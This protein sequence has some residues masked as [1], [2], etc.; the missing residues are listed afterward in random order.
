M[1]TIQDIVQINMNISEVVIPSVGHPMREGFN[2][3]IIFYGEHIEKS[4]WK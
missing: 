2:F 3:F 4:P 1:D